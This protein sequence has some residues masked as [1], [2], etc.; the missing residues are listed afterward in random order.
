MAEKI[1]KSV[2]KT[3]ATDLN[4]YLQQYEL[5]YYPATQKHPTDKIAL[6]IYLKSRGGSM[7]YAKRSV[8]FK[9]PDQLRE[10]I[11]E[12]TKA[13]IYQRKQRMKNAN[14]SGVRDKT[15]IGI[16]YLLKELRE[17]MIKEIEENE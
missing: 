14:I 11:S 8:F 16:H 1:E 2:L 17:K 7:K 9:S 3:V 12:L 15:M 13:W 6:Y 4:N 10:L 5:L